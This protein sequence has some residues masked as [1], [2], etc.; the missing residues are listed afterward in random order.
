MPS[1]AAKEWR[2]KYKIGT[3]LD[4]KVFIG[5]SDVVRFYRRH[6]QNGETGEQALKRTAAQIAKERGLTATF[7]RG[8]RGKADTIIFHR[9]IRRR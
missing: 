8:G 6:A 1:E 3:G 5:R 2:R 9:Q 7:K 4:N